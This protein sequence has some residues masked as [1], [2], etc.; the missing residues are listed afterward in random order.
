[1]LN[2]INRSSGMLLSSR[3]DLPAIKITDETV[4]QLYAK[5]GEHLMLESL[6]LEEFESTYFYDIP[7]ESDFDVMLEAITSTKIR[8]AATMRA[9]IRALNQSL[10]GTGIQAGND[11]IGELEDGTKSVGGANIGRVRRVQGIAVLSAQIPL[12]D[13][14]SISLI[15]HS[16]SGKTDTITN[17]DTLVAFRFLLNKRDVTNVV[18]PARG[19]DISLKQVTM[20][21][22]N[23]IER[24]TAKFQKAQARQA[25]IKSEI[26]T[27]LEEGDK[28]EQQ[29]SN[30]IEDGDK[31][32][33]EVAA[34]AEQLIAVNYQAN[35]Q[36]DLNEELQKE[37]D[38]A[39]LREKER[40][41]VP[42]PQPVE[43]TALTIAAR[44][45]ASLTGLTEDQ[46]QNWA[47]AK[48][49]SSES[50]TALSEALSANKTDRNVNAMVTAVNFGEEPPVF[51]IDPPDDGS[52]GN[53]SNADSAAAKAIE[54]LK[55]I[56][57]LISSD[58]LEIRNARGAVREAITALTAAGIYDENEGLVN[59]AAQHL[60][61]LL[62]GV[63]QGGANS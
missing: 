5:S 41:E 23:L 34:F 62:A 26:A 3:Q 47:N 9:F 36:E 29:Q 18:S 59:S 13:G 49:V 10:N 7:A 16:P 43:P 1:M 42:P 51:N 35:K 30:L 45:I 4:T 8:L 63:A 2:D 48:D 39:K 31:L 40:H 60:S 37:I 27:V 28:L 54:Y 15:F 38:S 24:N 33:A 11:K 14:Q 25:A 6:T 52:D 20:A 32:K 55:G 17:S 22:S 58:L 19:R 21:L 57:T 61:D 12:S 46:V 53:P 56:T 50:L 44:L